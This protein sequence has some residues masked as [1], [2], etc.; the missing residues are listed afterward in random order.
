M[1]VITS[2]K[3][4]TVRV[5]SYVRSKSYL[6]GP[7]RSIAFGFHLVRVGDTRFSLG[8]ARGDRAVWHVGPDGGTNHSRSTRRLGRTKPADPLRPQATVT[9]M[10]KVAM[11]GDPAIRSKPLGQ[12]RPGFGPTVPVRPIATSPRSFC[13][14][15]TP[16]C[17]PSSGR[18]P[19]RL[20][21]SRLIRDAII[22][23]DRDYLK[24]L[25]GG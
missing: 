9:P 13:N 6:S 14:P 4:T 11:A 22:L 5:T 21:A 12:P 24:L 20:A 19:I 18:T 7:R 15:T 1:S 8:A 16:S 2:S 3:Q 25:R 10:G 17:L 23:V